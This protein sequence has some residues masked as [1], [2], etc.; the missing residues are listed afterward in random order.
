MRI[1]VY[2]SRN[3][4]GFRLRALYLRLLFFI[5]RRSLWTH[6]FYVDDRN[7][8]NLIINCGA[9]LF[10]WH[11]IDVWKVIFRSVR[12]QQFLCSWTIAL[13]CD[14][15][16]FPS[17]M[18]LHSFECIFLNFLIIFFVYSCATVK[19]HIA[20]NAKKSI[21]S[22]F[23]FP[24]KWVYTSALRSIRRFFLPTDTVFREN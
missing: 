10:R 18:T 7:I 5:N 11:I 6:F 4:E 1:S 16:D 15:Y 12:H 22:C 13:A 19:K 21:C 9:P 8:A 20:F 24:S 14:S 17:Y 23:F 3:T 2:N